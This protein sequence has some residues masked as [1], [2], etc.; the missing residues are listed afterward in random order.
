MADYL[1]L[2]PYRQA[3][4]DL[5][6]GDTLRVNHDF[7]EAGED[8][9]RRLYLTRPS[10]DPAR[11]IGYCHNCQTGGSLSTGQHAKYRDNKHIQ[12]VP[13]P[14]TIQQSDMK[15]PPNL[16]IPVLEWPTH[17]TGWAFKNN[18]SAALIAQYNIGYDPSTN[19]VYLPR[20]KHTSAAKP[21]G[22]AVNLMGYQ[23]RN[24]DP[25]LDVPKYLT[26]VSDEDKGYTMMY[27]IV[28]G[29]TADTKPIVVIVEDLASG[30]RVIEAGG[31][32]QQ[33]IHCLVN[34]GTKVNLEALFHA[35]RYSNV[36]VWLDND[37]RHVIEQA[38]L[39]GRTVHLLNAHCEAGIELIRQDPKQYIEVEVVNA[40][41][42]AA[43]WI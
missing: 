26:V 17:A 30:I 10:A 7:C 4:D 19:R 21:S 27:G 8:T 25:A 12:P 43:D 22:M 32:V 2:S 35:S 13:T 29:P 37:S 34:Y 24:T 14:I 16:V 33:T 15:P 9:R 40:I 36:M 5:A 28:E 41:L 20:Y 11:I 23:L 3:C 18:L 39:M 6:P 38:E 31:K 1:T 42:D